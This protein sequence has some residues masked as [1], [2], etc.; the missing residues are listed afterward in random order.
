MKRRSKAGGKP[1]KSRRHKAVTPKRR[2]APESVSQETELTRRTRE[3]DEALEQQT[4]NSE[5][6]Q[7][8]PCHR[9]YRTSGLV[10][11]VNRASVRVTEGGF[12]EI[13]D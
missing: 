5:V 3:R 9:P 12:N 7:F 8:R 11:C 1:A 2:S 10:Q 4:A 6:W 13:S